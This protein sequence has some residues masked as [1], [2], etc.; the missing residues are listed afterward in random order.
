[1]IGDALR[2]FPAARLVSLEHDAD[3]CEEVSRLVARHG[4]EQV[5]HLVH[6][7]LVD[8][9]EDPGR[10]WYNP[11]LIPLESYDF[12]FVD[13]PPGNLC[14]K[15]REPALPVLLK[16]RLLAR[17]VL[18]VADDADRPEELAFLYGW[19]ASLPH[20]KLDFRWIDGRA[21]A[22]LRDRTPARTRR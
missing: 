4:L 6:A 17:N 5:V 22:T 20:S 11:E 1:V 10:R 18:V 16:R 12:V 8:W 13:G 14:P 19:Q 15:A 9:G 7:P 2:A 21:I 3:Y